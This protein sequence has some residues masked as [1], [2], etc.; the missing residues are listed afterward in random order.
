MT[1]QNLN[2]LHPYRRKII[3]KDTSEIRYYCAFNTTYQSSSRKKTYYFNSHI[4]RFSWL[5][6]FRQRKRKDMLHLYRRKE[7]G[8]TFYAAR[9]EYSGT[10]VQR[11]TCSK[12]ISYD[13]LIRKNMS[14]IYELQYYLPAQLPGKTYHFK[15]KQRT[16]WYMEYR[17]TL[18]WRKLRSSALLSWYSTSRIWCNSSYRL[19]Y[20]LRQFSQTKRKTYTIGSG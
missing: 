12:S 17:H 2:I 13:F 3:R 18:R 16:K 19:S 9:Q 10:P 8:K 7:Y 4:T 15:C 14:Q 11:A 5:S 1:T 20:L 6:T